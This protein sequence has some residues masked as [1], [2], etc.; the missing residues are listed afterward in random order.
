MFIFVANKVY[1]YTSDLASCCLVNVKIGECTG[2]TV[3]LKFNVFNSRF[4]NF[5]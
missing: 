2:Q 1:R 5:F 3:N 4:T